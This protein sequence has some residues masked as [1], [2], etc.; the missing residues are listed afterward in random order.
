MNKCKHIELFKSPELI[1]KL[2]AST[3][4]QLI[5]CEYHLHVKACYDGVFCCSN[6]ANC[7]IPVVIYVPETVQFDFANLRPTDWNPQYMPSYNMSVNLNNGFYQG[8]NFNQQPGN[9][10]NQQPGNNFNQQP[11]NNFNQQPG[12]NFNQQPGNNFNQQPGNYLNQ[13]NFYN[14]NNDTNNQN[15]PNYNSLNEELLRK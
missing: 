13:S 6:T 15:L 11:G 1:S 7:R 10:F 9:N 12:N 14:T 8:Q 5:D 2:Q 3:K 4:S